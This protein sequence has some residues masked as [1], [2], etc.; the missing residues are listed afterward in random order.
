VVTYPSPLCP[1]NQW[2]HVAVTYDAS[3]TIMKL[4][5]DA[6]EV[7]SNSA[8]PAFSGGATWIGSHNG[9]SLFSCQMDEVR[10]WNV[11]RTESQLATFMNTELEGGEPNLVAYYDMEDPQ[12]TTLSDQAALNGDANGRLQVVLCL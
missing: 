1:T 6:V 3:S 8:A 5:I 10:L 2:K 12:G 4:Y 9:G 7:A 11:A